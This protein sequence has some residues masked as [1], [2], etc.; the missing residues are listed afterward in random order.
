MTTRRSFLK[1]AA[2]LGGALVTGVGLGP[3]IAQACC[4]P[5]IL[6]T[7]Y[8]PFGGRKINTSWDVAQQV[9]AILRADDY[10]VDVELVPTDWTNYRPRILSLVEERTPIVVLGIGERGGYFYAPAMELRAFNK[11]QGT[12]A[13]GNSAPAELVPGGPGEIAAPEANKLAYQAARAAGY[14][15]NPSY[16]AGRFLCNAELYTNLSLVNDKKIAAGGF[17]HVPALKTSEDKKVGEFAQ[18][19]AETVRHLAAS[20]GWWDAP[21]R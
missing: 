10:Y 20:T 6:I 3:G 9:G 18:A 12:D 16:D 14:K 1:G 2:V 5:T 11:A 13:F 17:V 21:R 4:A 15:I 7:G 19:I 8:S